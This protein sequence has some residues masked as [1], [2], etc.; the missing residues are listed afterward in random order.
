MIVLKPIN[1]CFFRNLLRVHDNQSLY[2][3]LQSKHAEL[4]PVICLDPRMVDIS[5][6]NSKLSADYETPK[7]WNFKLE[8]CANYRT[9]FYI[10][11]IMSLKQELQKRKSDLLILYGKPE[12]LFPELKQYLIK[13]DYKLNQIHTHKEVNIN[14]WDFEE[15]LMNAYIHICC[16]FSM[17]LKSFKLRRH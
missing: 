14:Q 6:L 10:E 5:L 17:H 3:A 1:V 11:C 16:G 13:N 7:T 9:R 12:E 2:H 8:R 4:L 15:M